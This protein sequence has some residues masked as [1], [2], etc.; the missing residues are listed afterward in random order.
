MNQI[1]P[2]LKNLGLTGQEARVYLVLLELQEAQSGI[3]CK[4]VKIPSSYIYGILDKLMT[5][6]L[7]SY[8][9][10][11]NIR[12]FMPSSPECL[13]DLFLEKQA[14]LQKQKLEL[15]KEK[16]Q[17]TKLISILKKKPI[18]K[19]PS[20]HYKYYEGIS[21]IKALRH[22]INSIMGKNTTI[23]AY[24]C[25]M[26][27]YLRFKA[28]YKDHERL[29]QKNNVKE[30]LIFPEAERG[31]KQKKLTK[32]RILPLANDAEWGVVRDVFFIQY[33]VGKEPRGFII[34]DPFIA[35]TF[36]Q[37]FD[38]LWNIGEK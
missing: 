36:S 7:V 2:I 9:M 11:N 21:G 10:Q 12:V 4:T 37:V 31:R 3:L 15:E 6:G 1:I 32:Y 33:I 18:Q 8:R 26:K 23:K 17:V 19:K 28:M 14:H 38:F 22:E 24:T 16:K 25:K 5:K 13:Q 27:S 35:K 34:K 20:A 29:R 30:L